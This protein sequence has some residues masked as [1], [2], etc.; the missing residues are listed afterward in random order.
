MNVI[1]LELNKDFNP[2]ITPKKLLENP[3]Y[4]YYSPIKNS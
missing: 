3:S 4:T 1:P 2:L